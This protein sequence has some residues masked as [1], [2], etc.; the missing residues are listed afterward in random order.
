MGAEKAKARR[1]PYEWGKRVCRLCRL[2]GDMSVSGGA[3]MNRQQTV[4]ARG[5]ALKFFQTFRF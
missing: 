4:S 3:T 2:C 1:I 5:K